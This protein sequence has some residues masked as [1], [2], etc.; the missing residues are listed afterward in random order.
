MVQVFEKVENENENLYIIIPFVEEK[1]ENVKEEP[2]QIKSKF[3]I[4]KHTKQHQE[5][6]NIN[7]VK[8]QVD[9]IVYIGQLYN[10]Y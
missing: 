1:A 3:K 8:N 7:N 9:S 4:R 2:K 10:R 6:I 5:R